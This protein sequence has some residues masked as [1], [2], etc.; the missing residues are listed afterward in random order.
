MS[1]PPPLRIKV[2]SR[3]ASQ[4]Q[5]FHVTAFLPE[6]NGWSLLRFRTGNAA[7][8]TFDSIDDVLTTLVNESE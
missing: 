7:P 4:T 6:L 2:S 1:V 5:K 8:E 3:T